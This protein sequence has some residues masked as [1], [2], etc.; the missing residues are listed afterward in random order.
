[1]SVLLNDVVPAT[2]F[3]LESVTRERHRTRHHRLRERH[4]RAVETGL[5]DEPATGVAL[6]SP[7]AAEPSR[8][9]RVE[10][11]VDGIARAV[12]V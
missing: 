10:N 9:R 2:V 11:H 12:V 3:P 4:R 6:T 8:L 5:L 7:T 1:M